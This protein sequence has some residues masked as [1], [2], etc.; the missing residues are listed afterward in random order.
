MT[1]QAGPAKMIE[2]DPYA[3]R[4][5][6]RRRFRKASGL[7]LEYMSDRALNII[8]FR[9]ECQLHFIMQ[10]HGKMPS[11]LTPEERR[12]VNNLFSLTLE[13]PIS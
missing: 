5:P 13:L 6:A 9:L 11:E 10:H 8:S 2:R 3:T 7:A 4:V 12:E 1:N